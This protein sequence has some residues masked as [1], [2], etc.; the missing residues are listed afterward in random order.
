MVDRFET[1]LARNSMTKNIETLRNELD[2][3]LASHS[4]SKIDEFIKKA[5]ADFGLENFRSM[6][7]AQTRQ[8]I[9]DNPDP[10]L[11]E[12]Q[13]AYEQST[14]NPFRMEPTRPDF[15]SALFH[16]IDTRVMPGTPM[17]SW[18][19]TSRSGDEVW[20][21][22]RSDD[23]PAHVR[24]LA[25]VRADVEKAWYLEQARKLARDEARRIDD[26]LKKQ[27]AN[28]SDAVKFLLEQKQ[29][30]VFELANV[31][32]LVSPIFN[33]PGHKFTPADYQPYRAPKDRIAYPP[34]DFVDQ[35]L[36]LKEPGQSEVVADQPVKNYYVAVLM[37]KPQ[38]PERRE[39]YEIYNTPGREN[40]LWNEMMETRRRSYVQKVME[41]LR[42][43]A[44]KDVEDGE[45]KVNPDIRA[46]SESS[47][48]DTGE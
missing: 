34:N 8:E 7:S 37:E 31:A 32:H 4:E 28:P 17:R 25:T 38:V 47:S 26:E 39:F 43:E 22:W 16:P 10:A 18:Q 29:G 33:L 42:L 2:K 41:Q 23:K 6:K 40:R 9:L 45:Y 24:P 14:D 19:F 44:T 48:S 5:V 3:L 15:V 36:K 13:T 27:H 46:R 1:N 30:E 12:L 11:K 20:V 21:F 35:L